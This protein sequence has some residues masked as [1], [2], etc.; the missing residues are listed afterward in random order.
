MKT[1]PWN[2]DYI[3]GQKRPSYLTKTFHMPTNLIYLNAI[4]TTNV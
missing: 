4:N 3:I 1:S 2:K